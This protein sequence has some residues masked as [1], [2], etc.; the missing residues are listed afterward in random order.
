MRRIH[1]DETVTDDV[2]FRL[3]NCYLAAEELFGEPFFEG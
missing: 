2:T 1:D 3:H